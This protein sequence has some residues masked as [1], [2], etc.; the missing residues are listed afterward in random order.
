VCGGGDGRM[1]EWTHRKRRRE[2]D[3]G[4]GIPSHVGVGSGGPRKIVLILSFE[5]LNLYAFWTL[6]QGESTATVIMMLHHSSYFQRRK[7][8]RP[9][10]LGP[11]NAKGPLCTAQP[12]CTA[13]P[14]VRCHQCHDTERST[15]FISLSR[16]QHCHIMV[17]VL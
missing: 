5:M 12:T 11:L 8:V 6:E 17:K 2:W 4:E 13:T 14:L 16:K 3:L 15:L 10:R 9:R 7:N 1:D